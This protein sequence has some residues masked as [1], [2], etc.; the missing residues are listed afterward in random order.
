MVCGWSVLEKKEEKEKK[1]LLKEK[2]KELSTQ[3][4][5]IPRL[6]KD[7]RERELVN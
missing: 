5:E 7:R 1:I 6:I 2:K 3:S 4:W